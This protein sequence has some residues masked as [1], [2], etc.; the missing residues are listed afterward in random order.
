MAEKKYNISQLKGAWGAGRAMAE[1]Q[2]ND[3]GL[4][5]K[6]FHSFEEDGRVKWQG[7]IV[8]AQA[9]G[10]FLIQLYSWISG[11]PHDQKLIHIKDMVSWVFYEDS[12]DMICAYENEHRW[13]TDEYLKKCKI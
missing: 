5:G 12:E 3:K 8:S 13:K 11:S 1:K 4:I 7:R 10:L 9:E 2:P 6:W